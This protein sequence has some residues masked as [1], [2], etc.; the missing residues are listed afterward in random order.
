M[1]IYFSLL[2]IVLG[3]YLICA[4]NPSIILSRLLHH[5]DIRKKGS[6]NPGFTN[7]KRNYGLGEGIVVMALDVLK[8]VISVLGSALLLSTLY[9]NNWDLVA[10]RVLLPSDPWMAGAAIGTFFGCLGHAFPLYYGFKGG[11]ANLAAM[12]AFFFIDWRVALITISVFMLLLFTLHYM[13]LASIS[14]CFL[15]PI[16]LYFFNFYPSWSFVMVFPIMTSILVIARHH[17]NIKRL[18]TG[19]EKKFYFFK[20]SA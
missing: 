12:T 14:H 15:F 20:K 19:K 5:E 7:Y 18:C 17:E 3:S 6:G 1:N 10:P 8:T 4:L 16:V 2:I 9:K 13:S 11:K